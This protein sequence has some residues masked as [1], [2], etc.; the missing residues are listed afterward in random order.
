MFLRTAKLHLTFH[1]R[2]GEHIMTDFSLLGELLLLIDS[3][4]I[5]RSALSGCGVRERGV[6]LRGLSLKIC[7]FI[8]NVMNVEIRSL[9]PQLS[10]IFILHIIQH[11][12]LTYIYIIICIPPIATPQESGRH[13]VSGIIT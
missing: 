6:S 12:I 5:K 11:I 8:M 3:S 9:T 13:T 1:R 4:S 2:E 7:G 10:N